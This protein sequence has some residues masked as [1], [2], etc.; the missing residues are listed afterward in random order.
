VRPHAVEVAR[1]PIGDGAVSARVQRVHVAG[2]TV[3]VDL[4]TERGDLVQAEISQEQQRRL[5]LARED[6]V[7]V[8]PNESRVFS[9]DY[10][11]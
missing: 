10:S 6:T 11:I 5:A 3:K 2:P 7:Y 4:V 8:R 9:E 1:R